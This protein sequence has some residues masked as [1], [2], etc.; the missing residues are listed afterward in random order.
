MFFEIYFSI[1][2]SFAMPISLL[3][4][5]VNLTTFLLLESGCKSRAFNNISQIYLYLF[6]K[7]DKTF[8]VT[9]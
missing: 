4:Q 6:C 1:L 3:F 5:Y 8:F 9:H 7:E 2:N